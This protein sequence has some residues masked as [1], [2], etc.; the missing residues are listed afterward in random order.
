MWFVDDL[1]NKNI[2]FYKNEIEKERINFPNIN[3]SLFYGVDF[4]K[5]LNNEYIWEELNNL[6]K[7]YKINNKNINIE[8]PDFK[9][10]KDILNI[11]INLKEIYWNKLNTNNKIYEQLRYL[12]FENKYN[13]EKARKIR[14][15]NGNKK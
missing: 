13:L 9:N 14:L 15:K 10:S 6:L 12:L 2:N 5:S 11:L 8:I 4:F 7:E 3:I 1:F